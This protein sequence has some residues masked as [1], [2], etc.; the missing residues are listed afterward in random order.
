MALSP[1]RA[2]AQQIEIEKPPKTNRKAKTLDLQKELDTLNAQLAAERAAERKTLEEIARLEN[3]ERE[4][5]AQKRRL[6]ETA[7]SLDT[8]VGQEALKE[9]SR[10][11]RDIENLSSDFAR[12]SMQQQEMNERA[13]AASLA[14]KRRLE[15][16]ER[17]VTAARERLND[18][19]DAQVARLKDIESLKKQITEAQAELVTLGDSKRGYEDRKKELEEEITA[20]HQRM[21][22]SREKMKKLKEELESSRRRVNDLAVERDRRLES[23][24]K[25]SEG[26]QR[27]NEVLSFLDELREKRRDLRAKV[28]ALED[29]EV[30]GLEDQLE[31]I[32]RELDRLLKAHSE[33]AARANALQGLS[34]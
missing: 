18:E 32:T 21:G 23:G 7:R 2:S 5:T 22:E 29:N 17:A 26:N 14:A 16:A 25:Q 13:E 9:T 33:R 31:S 6:I 24:R 15:N 34:R 11:R 19:K 27:L 3:Q 28:R 12:L 4:A 1:R 20:A 8:I 10:L 30:A